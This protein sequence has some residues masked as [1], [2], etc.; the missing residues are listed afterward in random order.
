MFGSQRMSWGKAINSARKINNTM[1]KG[2]TPRNSSLVGI[3]KVYRRG[4]G[5]STSEATRSARSGLKTVKA[6]P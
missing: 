2:V 4:S 5:I 3:P 1:I 6:V